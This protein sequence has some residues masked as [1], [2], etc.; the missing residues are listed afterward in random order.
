[1][2]CVI[3]YL[4]QSQ[5]EE[6]ILLSESCKKMK[7]QTYQPIAGVLLYYYYYYYYI[8]ITILLLNHYYYY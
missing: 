1:M 6:Q 2:I 3:T 7:K 5:L 4:R 8:T